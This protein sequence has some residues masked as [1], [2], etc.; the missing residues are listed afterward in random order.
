MLRVTFLGTAGA[1]PTVNRFPSAIAVKRDGEEILLDCGEGTQ[2]QLM[3]TRTGMMNLSSIF[4]SHLHADHILGLP[5]LVQTLSFNGRSEPINVYGPRGTSNF[6]DMVCEFK[7]TRPSFP[8]HVQ[9][10]EQGEVVG[11]K[12][13]EVETFQTYHGVPSLGYIL[14]EHDRPGRFDRQGAINLGVSNVRDFGRLQRGMT[15]QVNGEEV[16]PQQVMGP[17]RPGRKV[18]YTGDTLPNPEI[19]EAF[20]DV[21]LA[22]CEATFTRKEKQRAMETYHCTAADAA[23]MAHAA[24]ARRLALTHISS[25]Y[26]GDSRPLKEEA[27]LVFP[28]AVL[29]Y[30]G[31]E[32]EVPLRDE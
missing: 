20:R 25:R 13:F 11:L 32:L 24:G 14:K 9:E 22:I 15:I 23:A 12:G 31:M 2:K 28:T 4:F 5:G 16:H 27:R 19:V 8:V 3:V 1:L 7:Y 21:D 18:V 10:L 6:I 29:A 17:P 30:D 26:T